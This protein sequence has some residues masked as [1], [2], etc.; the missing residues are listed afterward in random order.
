[1]T[2]LDDRK[3]AILS[4]HKIGEPPPGGWTTWFYIPEETFIRQLTCLGTHGWQVI[5]QSRFLK[6]LEDPESLPHRS[7]LLT[8]DDGY[9]SM[10]TV[11]LPLLKRFGFPAV[12]FVPTRYIG[13]RDTFG[14][15]SQPQEPICDWDDLKEL[16]SGGV[17]IQSH[18][19]S[20]RRFSVMNLEEQRAELLHSKAAL[21]E[22]LGHS[23][24]IFAFP[25]G[26]DGANPEALR[27]ELE[28]AG[29]RSA[30]LFKGGPISFPLANP[31]R[32]PRLAMGPD[33]DLEAALERGEF[34]P[35]PSSLRSTTTTQ[36]GPS[37]SGNCSSV[38]KDSETVARALEPGDPTAR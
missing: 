34:I 9:R 4:F 1:M 11:A 13:G 2:T 3:L 22:G 10:R 28:Q 25:Y 37:A 35:L 36:G 12:L 8:F 21:E 20:H 23:V 29:Y 31:Y 19:V 16:E 14:S 27:K 6:G 24:E 26:D 5:D 33:T 38:S 15:G 17:S 7:A 30:C 32:L 18:G